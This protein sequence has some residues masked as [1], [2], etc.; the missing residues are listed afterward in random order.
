MV[1]KLNIGAGTKPKEGYDNLDMINYNGKIQIIADL[2]KLPLPIKDNT[3]D[4]IEGD[5]ILEHLPNLVEVFKELYRIAKPGCIIKALVPHVASGNWNIDPTHCNKFNI[6]TLEI[7]DSKNPRHL[8]HPWG[9]EPYK[10]ELINWKLTFDKLKFMESLVKKFPGFY[11]YHLC[12]II[13]P[14]DLYFEYKVIK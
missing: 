8:I 6:Q 9:L 13:R 1:K 7:W 5:H 2:T 12:Y 3:Y 14:N 11:E 4:I 10:F